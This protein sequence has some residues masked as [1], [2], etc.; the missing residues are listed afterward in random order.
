M[1][2]LWTFQE[3]NK[4]IQSYASGMA[5]NSGFKRDAKGVGLAP[6]ATCTAHRPEG[7]LAQPS[8]VTANIEWASLPPIL[9]PNDLRKVVETIQPGILVFPPKIGNDVQSDSIY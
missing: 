3:A 1:K 5:S 8:S 7:I 2:L 9:P 4:R 6:F